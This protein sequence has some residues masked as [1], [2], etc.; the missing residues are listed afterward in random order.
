[1]AATSTLAHAIRAITTVVPAQVFENSRDAKA[2]TE[3]EIDA[4]TKMVGVNRRHIAEDTVCSSD[5]CRLAAIDVL[6]TL[7][8]APESVD[9]LIMVTQSP[10]YFLPSTAC[11]LHRALALSDRCAAFDVGLGCSGYTYGLWLAGMIL[12]SGGFRR[13]LLL[14]GRP[15]RDFVIRQTARSG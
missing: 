3:L 10:D 5:L 15:L 8:W 1:M 11:V 4:V 14:H 7:D 9:C 2:F 13:V 12:Q 6:A